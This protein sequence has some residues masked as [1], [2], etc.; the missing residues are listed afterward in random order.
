MHFAST[1]DGSQLSQLLRT[2]NPH[3]TLFIISSKS[4]TTIDTLSNA[5]TARCWLQHTL[6]DKPGVLHCH[7]LGVSSAVQKMTEWASGE[8][9]SCRTW[10]GAVVG[11][12]CCP[13]SACPLP[14]PM[15][16]T[17]FGRWF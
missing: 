3:S 6:G 9:I 10:T 13:A 12:W 14:W 11:T 7:F 15:A 4:F 8:G 2:L 5:D 16:L 17:A 1:M